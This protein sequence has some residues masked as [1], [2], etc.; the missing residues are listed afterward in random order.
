MVDLSKFLSRA[1]QALE[2]RQYDV[3]IETLEE[4]VDFAPD[5]LDIHVIHLEA[6]RRKAKEGPKSRWPS[7]SMPALTKDP[8]KQMIAAFKRLSGVPENKA[9]AEAGDA[10]LKLGQ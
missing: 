1:K 7:M 9:I 10:A 6:A 5:D 8:H 2:R 3:A 4:C